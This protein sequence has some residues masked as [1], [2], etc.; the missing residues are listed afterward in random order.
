MIYNASAVKIYNATIS[1]VRFE[2][3][4]V[5]VH[6]EKRSSLL[7]RCSFKFWTRGFKCSSN[8]GFDQDLIADEFVPPA[9]KLF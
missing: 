4:H 9:N 1:L 8:L 5:Y 3:K 6:F 2:N 7:Q